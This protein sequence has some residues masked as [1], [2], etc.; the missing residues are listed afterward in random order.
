MGY[1]LVITE[2]DVNDRMAPSA[3]GPRDRIVADYAKA[4]LDIMLSYPQLGDVLCWG[5]VDRY[6]WLEDFEPRR[7]KL[8]KRGTPYD[9]NFRPKLLREAIAAALSTASPAHA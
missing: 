5:M 8:P 6:S 9:R 3:I 7:D 1:K 2:F 4:Y